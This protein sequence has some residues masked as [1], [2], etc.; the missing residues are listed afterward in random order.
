MLPQVEKA[1]Q[2]LKEVQIEARKVTWP[3]RQ[4]AIG[5]TGIVVLMV[6]FIS[7]FLFGVDFLLARIMNV[8]LGS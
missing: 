1:V 4:E 7:L 2:F 8:V 5:A 6:A 3:S